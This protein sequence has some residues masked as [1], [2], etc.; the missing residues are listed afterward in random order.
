MTGS[1]LLAADRPRFMLHEV[2]TFPG[3]KLDVEL[4]LAWS[5]NDDA[6]R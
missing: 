5:A 6:R 1:S 2:Q 4:L 3:I